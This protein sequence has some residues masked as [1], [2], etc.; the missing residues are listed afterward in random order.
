MEERGKGKLS[1]KSKVVK[2]KA[3]KV[4]VKLQRE[5]YDGKNGV[6]GTM[7][8]NDKFVC[9][10]LELE[11]KDN[12]RRKSCIPKGEYKLKFRDY[13]GYHE[14]YKR[15]FEDHNAGMIEIAGVDGRSAILIHCGNTVKD[16]LGCVLVGKEADSTKSIVYKSKKAYE[17]NVYPLLSKLLKKHKE[18]YLKI[19]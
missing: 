10:T 19:S 17:E 2:P 1:P 16:T 3:K 8:F 7:S 18:V 13:G 4:V 5:R 12:Q 14:R 9:Y 11:W 6:I 15:R